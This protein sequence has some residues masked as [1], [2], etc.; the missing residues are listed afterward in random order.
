MKQDTDV[1]CSYTIGKCIEI[2]N[3]NDIYDILNTISGQKYKKS[4][5]YCELF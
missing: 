1:I 5:I 2:K 4:I 3:W